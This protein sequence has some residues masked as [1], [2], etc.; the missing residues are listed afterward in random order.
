MSASNGDM[1][2]VVYRALVR[3]MKRLESD[4]EARGREIEVLRQ[5]VATLKHLSEE[6]EKRNKELVRVRR[7]KALEEETRNVR[8]VFCF[9]CFYVIVGTGVSAPNYPTSA[10]TVRNALDCETSGCHKRA[11]ARQ[12]QDRNITAA[13]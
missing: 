4:R 9:S 3:D 13:T 5:E 2:Q 10:R 7:M 12:R 11:G 6:A 8:R 1:S